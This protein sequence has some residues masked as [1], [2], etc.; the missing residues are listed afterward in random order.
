MTNSFWIALWKGVRA[1]LVAI[2]VVVLGAI[3]QALGNF[4]PEPGIQTTVWQLIG[5]SVIGAV[6]ALMNWL[7]NKDTKTT[8]KETHEEVIITSVKPK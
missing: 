5:S 3:V 1:F 8:V 4:H 2:A 6:I 7:K